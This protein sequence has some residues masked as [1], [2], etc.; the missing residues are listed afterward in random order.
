[1]VNVNNHNVCVSRVDERKEWM[2]PTQVSHTQIVT[3][4]TAGKEKF[5]SVSQLL[6][7]NNMEKSQK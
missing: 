3:C 6:Y 4:E 1:M 5:A 7:N 2:S